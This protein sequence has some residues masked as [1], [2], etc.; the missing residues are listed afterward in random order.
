MPQAPT[1]SPRQENIFLAFSRGD[2]ISLGGA[3]RI[4]SKKTDFY[5]TPVHVDDSQPMHL[6]LHGP[7]ERHPSER[8][9]VKANEEAAKKAGLRM[10]SQIGKRKGT[11]FSGKQIAP[12]AFLVARIRWSWH[13]QRD[14]FRNVAKTGFIRPLGEHD[15][16]LVLNAPLHPNSV[17][18]V[19]LVLSHNDPYW[20]PKEKIFPR[21]RPENGLSPYLGPLVNES[22]LWLT[23]TSYH[24]S[25]TLN[26]TPKGI[27]PPFP[28]VTEQPSRILSGAI[29]PE[30]IYW[31]HETITSEEFLT[32]LEK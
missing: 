31:M 24:R 15:Q 4:T 17:W 16:G 11:P 12:N 18:D 30:G 22:G 21:A 23:G 25:E 10:S 19:D 28:T 5:L 29:G 13:L 6:S 3:W 27:K 32:S 20:P 9:H 14:K 1:G 7:N 26:P 8:F 2:N